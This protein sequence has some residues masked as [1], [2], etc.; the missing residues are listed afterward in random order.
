MRSDS[1]NTLGYERKRP[2]LQPDGFGWPER[3][4]ALGIV[5]ILLAI[6]VPIV[7]KVRA[8]A[9]RAAATQPPPAPATTTVYPPPP[10]AD[11]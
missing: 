9:Q 6:L 5:L 3:V 1:A 10:L 8:D 11:E 4:V 2:P 7:Q